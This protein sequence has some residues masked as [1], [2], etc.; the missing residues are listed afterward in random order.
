MKEDMTWDPPP[1]YAAMLESL[2]EVMIPG[3]DEPINILDLCRDHPD[4]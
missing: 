3:N 4:E 2:A 1:E